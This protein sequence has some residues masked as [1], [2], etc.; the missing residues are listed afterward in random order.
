MRSC[1]VIGGLSILAVFTLTAGLAHGQNI[2]LLLNAKT[3]N[4]ADGALASWTG[5]VGS[6]AASPNAPTFLNS[7]NINSMPGVRFSNSTTVP[8][9]EGMV[10][11][12][13]Q[14]TGQYTVMTLYHYN[15]TGNADG[16]KRVVQGS[17]SNN[18]LMGPFGGFH[19]HHADGFVDATSADAKPVA[20]RI[21]LATATNAAIN[22]AGP[23]MFYVNGVDHTSNSAL[24][25][26]FGTLGLGSGGAFP[27]NPG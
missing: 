24:A 4:Q 3:I 7:S 5:E 14:T 27:H 19:R 6:A 23:S 11:S 18:W 9:Q 22:V 2:T 10:S 25:G 20:D 1:H 13:T 8:T 16:N 15:R 26:D 12:L 21:A 17:G